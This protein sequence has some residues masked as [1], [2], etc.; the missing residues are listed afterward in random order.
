[1]A[2]VHPDG[3]MIEEH[4]R[5]DRKYTILL[6]SGGSRKEGDQQTKWGMLEL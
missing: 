6:V 5:E 1:M 4:G 2:E 3:Q